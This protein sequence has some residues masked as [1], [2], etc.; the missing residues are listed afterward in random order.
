MKGLSRCVR[1]SMVITEDPRPSAANTRPSFPPAPP[2]FS[3]TGPHRSEDPLLRRGTIS[4][5][6][7]ST[8]P[9]GRARRRRRDHPRVRGEHRRFGRRLCCSA[10]P[11]RLR[12]EHDGWHVLSMMIPGPSPR[13]RGAPLGLPHPPRLEGTLPACAGSTSTG[14]ATCAPTRDP[15]PRARGA[16]EKTTPS[17]THA[18]TIPACAGSTAGRAGSSVAQWDHPRVRGEHRARGRATPGTTG[19]SPRARGAPRVA[20]TSVVSLG[21]IPAGAGSTQPPRPATS[22]R[23]DHPRGRGEHRPCL[24]LVKSISGPSPRARGALRRRS[25]RRAQ[26]G[27]SPRARG[28]LFFTCG[29]VGGRR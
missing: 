17:R 13:A 19:P 9:A 20:T 28:A 8:C 3:G 5:C 27:P 23:R 2:F 24:F 11:P 16:R 18:G 22:T 21:T 29:D 7:G 4:A 6:A 15:S 10:G 26:A 25:N 1:P 14:S 12:G